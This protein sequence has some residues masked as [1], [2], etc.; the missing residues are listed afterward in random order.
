[1]APVYLD[2][3]VILLPHKDVV[4]PPKWLTDYFTITPGGRHA[5]GQTDNK[6]IVFQDGSYIE[7]IAFVDD[8]PK[9]REGHRWGN[10][11]VGIIDFALITKE[12]AEE[13]YKLLKDRLVKADL[14]VKYE[15]PTL[16]GR[17]REDGKVLEWKVTV[18]EPPA[19]RG[20]TPFFCHD[21]TPRGLRVPFSS[22]STSHKSGAYGVTELKIYL[23][24]ER[25]SDI[26]KAY[27]AMLEAKNGSEE[28]NIG[29]FK[30]GSLHPVK[31]EKHTGTI[32][33]IQEPAEEWQKKVV[34]ERGILLG[35]LQ[36]GRHSPASGSD[37][38]T[39]LDREYGLG[40]IFLQADS[41]RQVQ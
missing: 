13:H 20:E 31:D 36:I 33:S 28:E 23:P 8:D 14:G 29:V 35:D 39:R 10:K 25:V 30:V 40:R 22:G 37:Q 15:P 5:G 2:H 24:K 21:V 16:G 27:S 19:E 38:P 4:H 11:Q 41:R 6:L 9:H 7:L 12:D 26:A 1:M 34:A 17:K 32:L 3:I 18:P